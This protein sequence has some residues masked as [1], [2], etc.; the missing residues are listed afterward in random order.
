M[1]DFFSKRTRNQVRLQRLTN[2]AWLF[3]NSHQL[4]KVERKETVPVKGNICGASTT[5]WSWL[6]ISISIPHLQNIRHRTQTAAPMCN[7]PLN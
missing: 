6:A 5:F 7:W 4:K 2:S 3:F 1:D